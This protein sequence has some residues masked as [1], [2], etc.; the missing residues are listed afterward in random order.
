MIH[1]TCHSLVKPPAE[2]R[3]PSGRRITLDFTSGE[4]ILDSDLGGSDVRD[5]RQ[6]SSHQ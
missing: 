2:D 3:R 4:F 5:G 1:P 6:P